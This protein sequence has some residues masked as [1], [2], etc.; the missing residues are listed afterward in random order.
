[1]IY[2]PLYNPLKSHSLLEHVFPAFRNLLHMLLEKRLYFLL[3]VFDVS[4]T[5]FNNVNTG[6]IVQDGI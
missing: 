4:G 6:A 5:G 3:D 2:R 1:M